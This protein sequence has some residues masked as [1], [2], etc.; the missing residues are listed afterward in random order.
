MNRRNF[1]QCLS[2]I[3]L[4]SIPAVLFSKESDFDRFWRLAKTGLVKGDTFHLDRTIDLS[5]LDYPL[6]VVNCYFT[7]EKHV[8]VIFNLGVNNL[9]SVHHCVFNF[10]ALPGAA[11]YS[12]PVAGNP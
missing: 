11:C 8:P 5:N 9:S 3:P 2:V 12:L 6:E 7:C 4:L 10:N 1:L